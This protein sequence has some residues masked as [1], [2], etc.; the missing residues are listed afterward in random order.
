[1][2]ACPIDNRFGIA[3]GTYARGKTDAEGLLNVT[4]DLARLRLSRDKS[5]IRQRADRRDDFYQRL[6]R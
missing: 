6:K 5:E 2:V 3:D 4:L 1:M